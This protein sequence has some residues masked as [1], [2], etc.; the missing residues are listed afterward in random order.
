VI[1]ARVTE[2]ASRTRSCSPKYRIR[3]S[4][5]LSQGRGGIREK[6]PIP[7]LASFLT[8]RI[9]PWAEATFA[10]NTPKNAKWYR[11]ECRVL[12]SYKPLADCPLDSITSELSSELAAHRIREGKQIATVNSSLWVLRRVLNLGVE[13][14]VIAAAPRLKVL[15]RERRRE[16]VVSGEEEAKYLAVASEPFA[17]SLLH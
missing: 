14:A 3:A 16:R 5:L 2:D 7:S 17:Q 1:S 8:E 6:K 9:L 12:K 15:S 4:N 10:S 13:W 11:N